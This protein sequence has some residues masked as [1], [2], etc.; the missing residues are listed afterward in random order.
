[1]ET[2]ITFQDFA[3]LLLGAGG[4]AAMVGGIIGWLLFE[5]HDD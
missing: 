5:R 4:I 1:M 2:V 3:L